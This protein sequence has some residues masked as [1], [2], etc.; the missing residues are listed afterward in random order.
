MTSAQKVDVEMKHRLPCPGTYV[1][2]RAV[3]FLDVA[4]AC[5]LRCGEIAAADHFGVLS[6][7]FLPS[8]KM[9]LRDYQH[10]R[11][12]FGI[13]VLK[14]EDVLILVD[15]LRGNLAAQN[16]AE[17]TVAGGVDGH[18]LTSAKR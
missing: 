16:A 18:R 12:G 8:G 4:L 7:S 2:N 3:S 1:Q 9:F 15:F 5:D 11:R 14:G 10:V 6:L 17:K 13:D